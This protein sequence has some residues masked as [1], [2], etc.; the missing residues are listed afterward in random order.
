[1]TARSA[2]WVGRVAS[3]A[4]V[5]A[6][7]TLGTSGAEAELRPPTPSEQLDRPARYVTCPTSGI[8]PPGSMVLVDRSLPNLGGGV[9]GRVEVYEAAGAELQIAV[10]VD[11]L[12][13]YDDL[14]FATETT[15]VQGRPATVSTAAALGRLDQLVIVTWDEPAE[16]AACTSRAL[17]GSNL[18]ARELLA[19]ANDEGGTG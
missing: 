19:I 1:M 6:G 17:V 10:G 18:P 15:D 5:C 9:L 4:M 12:D 3:L 13:R 14:D 7:C 16:V 8:T 2:T 11:V